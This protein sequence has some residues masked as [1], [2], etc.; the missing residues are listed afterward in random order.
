MKISVS[1]PDEDVAFLDSRGTNRSAAIHDAIEALRDGDL[2]QEYADAFDE[3]DADPD[4]KA[5]NVTV[6]DGLGE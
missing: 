3:W 6:A 5:W 1:L 2:G 4:N